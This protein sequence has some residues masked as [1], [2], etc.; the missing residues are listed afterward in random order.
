MKKMNE[1]FQDLKIDKNRSAIAH[2]CMA[3]QSTEA[4][5]LG[6]AWELAILLLIFPATD[7]SYGYE[8]NGGLFSFETYY[9]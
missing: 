8:W 5:L 6:E 2:Q 7:M 4:E 9:I 3:S 1:T